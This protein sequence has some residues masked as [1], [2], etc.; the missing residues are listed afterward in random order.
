M[1]GRILVVDDEDTLRLTLKARLSSGGFEVDTARDGEEA[2]EKLKASTFDVVLLDINMPRMDGITTLGVVTEVY[3]KLDVIMLTGF[4]D[5]STAIECLK[6]GA[7][8]YLVKPIDTTELIT[9]MR[10]L[11]RARVSE[12]ALEE[13]KKEHAEAVLDDLLGPLTYSYQVLGSLRKN[14]PKGASER[15]TALMGHLRDLSAL[16][17]ERSVSHLDPAQLKSGGATHQTSAQVAEAIIALPYERT[18]GLAATR[19]VT[20][21]KKGEWKSVQIECNAEKMS[22]ALENLLLRVVDGS[23]KGSHITVSV[24]RIKEEPGRVDLTVQSS[25]GRDLAQRI[26]AVLGRSQ[27]SLTET[28]KNVKPEDWSLLVSR[29]LVELDGGTLQLESSKG[30]EV[31]ITFRLKAA[32]KS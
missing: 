14:P 5:F 18:V 19:N 25:K 26:T 2:L 24:A 12:R 7:K 3:P 17:I 20:L 13:L 6:A 10:S 21:E 15:E 22:L 23:D 11:L 27:E 4:A 28:L 1:E 29:R 8:D 9:R 16:M 30:S 31:T 32:G